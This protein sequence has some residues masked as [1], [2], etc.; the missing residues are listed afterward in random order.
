MFKAHVHEILEMIH[1]SDKAYSVAELQEA[2]ISHF[3]EDT[4]FNSCSIHDMSA[5]QAIEFLVQRG[6]FVPLQ[7]GSPCCGG[8]G[9]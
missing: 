3:S 1:A 7:S 8:C 9:G 6:K 4:V 5:A 2:V